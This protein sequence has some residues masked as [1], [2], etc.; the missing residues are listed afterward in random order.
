MSVDE[1]AGVRC[2]PDHDSPCAIFQ[3][4][5]DFHFLAVADPP[6]GKV[7][8]FSGT[9][10]KNLDPYG[11]HS[12]DEIWKVTEEVGLKSIIEQF[13]G[14]LDFVL[15]DGGCVLSH[16]HKQLVCL[17]RSVLSKAKILLLDEPSAH[18]D[19]ITFQIIR[20]TLKHAFANC[21]V[22]LSEHR[23]EAMLECQFFLVIEENTVRQYDSIQ[24][25][26]NEKSFFKQAMSHS[27]RLKLFP[28]HRRNS[29]K[30]KSRPK[31]T[32]LQEETEEEAQ[33]TRL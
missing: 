21:T 25:I 6:S 12:D 3:H 32:A 31:I 33:E 30:R 18:L 15:L 29:S 5:S 19:P 22:I 2:G 1:D 9:F 13:P 24:K 10:R 28:L 23:L 7:F 16:G 11:K 14:Q 27:D 17:A 8:I 26:M 4:S 20:K